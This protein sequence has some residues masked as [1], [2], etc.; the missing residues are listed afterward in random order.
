MLATTRRRISVHCQMPKWRGP[1][2]HMGWREVNESIMHDK[3]EEKRAGRI[4]D[5]SL[6][7]PRP[8]L[9]EEEEDS[10]LL[11]RAAMCTTDHGRP[12]YATG[13]VGGGPAEVGA[14]HSLYLRQWRW[15]QP[16][17]ICCCLSLSLHLRWQRREGWEGVELARLNDPQGKLQ[18]SDGV[19]QC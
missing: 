15:C 2:G 10:S 7:S 3:G 13:G 14:L 8:S 17:H 12:A 18:V 4:R 5:T 11:S 19:I 1:F 6:F 9:Y 16:H